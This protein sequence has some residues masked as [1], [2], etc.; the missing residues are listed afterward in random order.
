MQVDELEPG[1]YIVNEDVSSNPE[2]M[3]LVGENDISVKVEVGK[4]AEIKTAEFTNNMTEVGSLKIKKNVKVNG[5]TTT[6]DKAD[7]TYTVSEDTSKNPDGM[8]LMGSNDKEIEVQAGETAEIKTAEFTNNYSESVV[9]EGEIK[10]SI[11]GVKYDTRKHKVVIEVVD[12]G[13]G[14]LA[15]KKNTQLIRTVSITNTYKQRKPI[16]ITGDQGSLV[17]YLG[18]M[19]ASML[20]LLLIAVFRRSHQE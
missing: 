4:T 15:A 14:H 17:V 13:K 12:D 6:G 10:G 2:G 19:I 3:A 20:M 11:T 9:A 7:G 1:T 16:I 5:E 8:T 18:L